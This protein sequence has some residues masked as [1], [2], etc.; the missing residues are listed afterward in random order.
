MPVVREER[1]RGLRGMSERRLLQAAVAFGC[2]VPIVGGGLGVVRG[3][4]MVGIAAASAAADAHFRYLSGLLLGIGLGFLSTVPR[5]EAQGARFRLLAAIVV[6]GGLGRLL[7]LALRGAPD[8]LTLFALAMELAVTPSLALWQ[9]R[10]ARADRVT[11]PQPS[12]LPARKSE[13]CA[14]APGRHP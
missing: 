3:P 13:R 14:P 5:I 1:H 7:S 8:A 10:I 6:I 12:P 4:A 2:L 11:D 9:G